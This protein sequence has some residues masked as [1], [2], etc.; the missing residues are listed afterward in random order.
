MP[1]VSALSVVS[2]GQLA[3]PLVVFV[4]VTATTTSE[5]YHRL[6]PEV[7]EVKLALRDEPWGVIGSTS[8]HRGPP[9]R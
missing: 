4:P 3:M 9:P 1:L 7:P 2:A 8:S 6:A 5:V